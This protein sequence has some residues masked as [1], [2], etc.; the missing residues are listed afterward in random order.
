VNFRYALLASLVAGVCPVTFFADPAQAAPC[1]GNA[2]FGSAEGGSGANCGVLNVGETF[3]I[4]VS[5][6]FIGKLNPPST[7]SF[8]IGIVK[9]TGFGLSFSDVAGRVKGVAGGIPFDGPIAIW[10]GQN[11]LAIGT[12]PDNPFGSAPSG[13]FPT[14]NYLASDQDPGNLGAYREVSFTFGNPLGGFGSG[15]ASPFLIDLT[16]VESFIIEGTLTGA[17]A[18]TPTIISF[19]VGPGGTPTASSTFGGYFTAVPGPLPIL[20]VGAAFGW[21]RSLRRRIKSAKQPVAT[22]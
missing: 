7:T 4:D 22:V 8:G 9:G 19:G 16:E 1:E 2:D 18:Q 5:D 12:G 6:F 11:T 17:S 3:S 21:S 14:T 13:P 15:K 20:G 10:G